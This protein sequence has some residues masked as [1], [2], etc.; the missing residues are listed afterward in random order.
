ME[1]FIGIEAGGTKF[2]CAV[3][4][5]NGEIFDRQS[6]ATETPELT[7]P[8]IVNYIIYHASCYKIKAIGVGCFG[9]IDLNKNSSYYGCITTTPKLRWKYC[10]I[11]FALKKIFNGPIFFDTDVN[12]AALGEYYFGA[13]KHCDNF[14]Y[15]TVGT[16]I[17]GGVMINNKLLH[18]TTHPELGHMLIPHDKKKDPFPGLCSFHDNC[19]EGLASGPAINKRW[20][21]ESCLDLSPDHQAWDLEAHYLA[22]ACANF[23]LAFSPEKIILGGGVITIKSNLMNKIQEKVPLIL[24]NYIHQNLKENIKDYIVPASLGENAGIIGTIVLAVQCSP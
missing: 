5:R 3:G 9:P 21:T 7:L 18:G 12:A 15:L 24:N 16:G 6:F 10:N 13:A 11:I 20:N 17:G 8:K 1:R 22:I 2:I 23:T 4:N 14:I 19:L